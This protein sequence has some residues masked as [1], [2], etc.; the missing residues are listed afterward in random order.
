MTSPIASA[1]AALLLVII[2]AS[3]R[4]QTPPQTPTETPPAEPAGSG[5][6]FEYGVRFG[7][8][9][10]SLT[11]VEAFDPT[12]VA[13]ASEPTM[14][15]GGFF[16]IHL[17]GAL[18]LQPEVLFASKGHRIR[19]RDAQS[20]IA[21]DGS[22]QPAP[23][24]RVILVRYLEF[25]ILLRLSKQTHARTSLYLVGGPAFAFKRDKKAVI[26]GVADPG[27]LIDISDEVLGTNFLF[28]VGGGLQ[29]KRWLVDARVTRGMRNIAVT[30][31]PAEVK[32]NAFSVLMGVRF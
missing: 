3:V 32:T 16:A 7:P 24:S 5:R 17:A 30:P 9:F 19:D 10:T 11:S 18:A 22:I 26:R 8:S 25:P 28:I 4:A 31:Q 1:Y 23:A 20:T 27:V 2:A 12:E 29:H 13:V 14:N 15:F 21:S 6:S